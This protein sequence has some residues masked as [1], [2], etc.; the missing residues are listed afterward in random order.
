MHIICGVVFILLGVIQIMHYKTIRFFDAGYILIGLM[1]L[2]I[3]FK[4]S[5]LPKTETAFDERY[6]GL[7]NKAGFYAFLSIITTV[8]I[9]SWMDILL[10]YTKDIG[11][12]VFFFSGFE[13]TFPI[14]IRSIFI[15]TI[16]IMVFVG[17]IAYYRKRGIE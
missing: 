13:N 4:T 12:S 17:L 9:L 8:I 11:S 1:Y 2:F 7:R 5:T 16:G 3:A 15:S 10:L 14:I 6:I